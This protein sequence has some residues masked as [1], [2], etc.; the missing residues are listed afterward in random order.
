[1]GA[2]SNRTATLES[3][4]IP[5]IQDVPGQTL[6]AE[7]LSEAGQY[8]T[9]RSKVLFVTNSKEVGPPYI[10]GNFPKAEVEFMCLNTNDPRLAP[11]P[12]PPRGR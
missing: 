4:M 3:Q 10:M 2:P 5:M 7:A 1:M 9:D 8:C 12:P 6:K 11:P